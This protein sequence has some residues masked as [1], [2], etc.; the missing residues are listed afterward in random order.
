MKTSSIT[1]ALIILSSTLG[2]AGCSSSDASHSEVRVVAA[3]GEPAAGLPEGYLYEGF[4]PIYAMGAS[5][6][7]A[8]SAKA[9]T[10]H[11]GPRDRQHVLWFG[12]VDEIAPVARVGQAVPGLEETV[13][14][15]GFQATPRVI[16]ESGRLGFVVQTSRSPSG[17]LPQALLIHDDGELEK[18]VATG[19]EVPLPGGA[20]PLLSI[21]QFAMTNEGVLFM[22][23]VNRRQNGLWFWDHSGLK[24]VSADR[25]QI[26]IGSTACDVRSVAST[27]VDLNKAGFGVFRITMGGNQCASGGII[28]WDSDSNDLEP[29][30]LNRTP[31][32]EGSDLYYQSLTGDARVSDEGQVGLHG[33]IYSNSASSSG[34]KEMTLLYTPEHAASRA[35]IDK[36]TP[37]AEAPDITLT[38]TILGDGL[39]I[40]DDSE[41]IHFVKSN[42]DRIILRTFIDEE[43]SHRV[44]ARNGTTV[45]EQVAARIGDGHVNRNGDVVF[46]SYIDDGAKGGTYQQELWFSARNRDPIRLAFP[47]Q[48]VAGR[49]DQTIEGIDITNQSH[50]PKMHNTQGGRNRLMDDSGATFF[51]GRLRKAN[52][53]HNALFMAI[54]D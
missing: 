52:Q 31:I 23:K 13:L 45:G 21:S 14:I 28:A 9:N 29:I 5:G 41:L 8:F 2:F 15:S 1:S 44:V 53:W 51:S 30:A 50:E 40:V 47:G 33:N 37:F 36:Y 17:S 35:L 43:I 32:E 6:E 10:P 22:G 19:D 3:A 11:G 26:N 25:T 39:A 20:T 16:T 46:T 49:T 24:L 48:P 27:T 18:V 54:P 12:S 34:A 7:I 42:R 38:H 4:D